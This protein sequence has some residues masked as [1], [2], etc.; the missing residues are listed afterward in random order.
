MQ[1]PV[2]S[3]E[4][5]RPPILDHYSK[6]VEG[7]ASVVFPPATGAPAETSRYIWRTPLLA[8]SSFATVPKF[9]RPFADD[10]GGK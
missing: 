10:A 4:W 8:A 5:P 3:A 9:W 6:L 2:A 7:M 1:T